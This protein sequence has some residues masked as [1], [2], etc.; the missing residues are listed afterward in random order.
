[1]VSPS[2]VLSTVSIA[3]PITISALVSIAF[4]ASPLLSIATRAP[5]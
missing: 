3:Q 4:T 2:S 1:M 5:A